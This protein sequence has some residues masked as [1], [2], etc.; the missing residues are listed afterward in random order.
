MVK[1]NLKLIS[2]IVAINFVVGSVSAEVVNEDPNSHFL[3]REDVSNVRSFK[4]LSNELKL[5]FEQNKEKFRD[6]F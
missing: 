6:L 2:V 3:T 1:I 5:H 4:Q